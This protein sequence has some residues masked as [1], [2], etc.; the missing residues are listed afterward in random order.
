VDTEVAGIPAG[1]NGDED[2][3]EVS[4]APDWGDPAF[5]QNQAAGD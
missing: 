1:E 5:V 4:I 3:E 2:V